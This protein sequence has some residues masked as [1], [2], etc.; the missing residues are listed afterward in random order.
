MLKM[1][2]L[3]R[4]QS[5]TDRKCPMR[6][7]PH[8]V[9]NPGGRERSSSLP[10]PK[11]AS[12]E[13][14][15][16]PKIAIVREELVDLTKDPIMAIV[17]NQLL[18][19]GRRVKDVDLFLEEETSSH[20]KQESP[21]QYGWFYKSAPELIQETMLGVGNATM[22]KY[23]RFLIERGW[24]SERTNPLYKWDRTT[25]YRI[26][27]KQLNM[28][29]QKLG[30]TLPGFPSDVFLPYTQ[31]FSSEEKS[32]EKPQISTTSENDA[33]K[34]QNLTFEKKKN[35]PSM[36]KLQ[37][38]EALDSAL[39]KRLPLT[40]RSVK[41]HACNTET[42][43]KTI[44][45]EHTQ[46]LCARED[47][48]EKFFD[49]I[50][51]TWKRWVGQE[52]RLTEKRKH[53]LNS[54][55]TSAFNNDLSTWEKFCER[56]SASPFLMGG[57][58]RRWKVSLDWILSENN[59]FKV[60]EGNF[61]NPEELHAK[62]QDSIKANQ[63]QEKTDILASIQDP[64]WQEWCTQL[65]HFEQQ[66]DPLSL[67]TLKEMTNA[68]FA[69][70]DG[71]LVWIESEDPKVLNR[72]EDLRLKLLTIV[73]RTFPKARNIRTR[74][75]EATRSSSLHTLKSDGSPITSTA[76]QGEAHGK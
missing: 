57:G 36:I 75:K 76:H 6:V 3:T 58:P 13:K 65:T 74:S 41:N 61:D 10:S 4:D 68:N 1:S 20:S 51:A 17:L 27:L 49:K 39:S 26:N 28:D 15:R 7:L 25:Q 18:Y 19:W 42:T 54:L 64:T 2:D 72:I 24:V 34:A 53:Q 50:L 44:N 29:L 22:R 67:L 59:A 11:R 16:E 63:D 23:L 38:F 8:H 32:P 46:R 55:L 21:P 71:R 35:K 52:V 60:L 12:C 14:S 9:D 47:F 70:F 37:S 56:V 40:S 73:Q 30:W 5:Q 69:E 33:S 43:P 45:K 31:E 48:N 62:K 66:K